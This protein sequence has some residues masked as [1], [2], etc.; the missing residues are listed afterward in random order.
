M[1]KILCLTIVVCSA[2]QFCSVS[3]CLVCQTTPKVFHLETC[4]PMLKCCQKI[5]QALSA[6]IL[7]LK[8]SNLLTSE[9][10]GET[11][12]SRNHRAPENDE[13]SMTISDGGISIPEVMEFLQI[14]TRK[15]S[16]LHILIFSCVFICFLSAV[17]RYISIL[18][19][20]WSIY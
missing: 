9:K 5:K 6:K 2:N 7:L 12:T 3:R 14:E 19:Q 8:K 1:M 20:H 18:R 4:Q 13:K 15:A 16:S 11:G 17:I 10:S